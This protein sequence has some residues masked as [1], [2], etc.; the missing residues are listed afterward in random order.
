MSD[1]V[2]YKRAAIQAV[3]S[4]GLQPDLRARPYALVAADSTL[5]NNLRTLIK[6]IPDLK[7][8]LKSSSQERFQ[9]SQHHAQKTHSLM[10][11]S[12]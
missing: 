6:V 11:N 10:T 8:W 4:L 5:G 2:E 3:K 1:T 7:H 12:L 9:V